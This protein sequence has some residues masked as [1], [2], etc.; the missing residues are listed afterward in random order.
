VTAN[1]AVGSASALA[2]ITRVVVLEAVRGRVPWLMLAV[3]LAGAAL[4]QFAAQVAI[5]ESREI[6][7]GL[8]GAWL[9]VAAVFVIAL[10]VITS[11]VRD[12][13]DKGMELVLALALPR[14]VYL[15]GRLA[16]YAAVAAGCA[17]ACTLVLVLFVPVLP[18]AVWGLTLGLELTIIAALALLCL[19]TLRHVTLGLS[20][21]IAFYLLAR[22][23]DAIRLIGANPLSGGDRAMHDALAAV[24]D[25]LAFVLPDLTL[26]ARSEWL[27]HLNASGSD[28]AGAFAQAG[29][30]LTLLAGA[31]LFDL[32][33]KVL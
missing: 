28:L 15:G 9:R 24:L 21:V 31:A 27:I 18:A 23:I 25:T 5:T 29:I 1:R 26:F 20:A 30:Y 3:L 2:A 6:A 8:L 32:Q 4:S 19:L 10:F 11:M 12:L 33:R 7:N 16:G 13:Q 22:S 14:A 17:L